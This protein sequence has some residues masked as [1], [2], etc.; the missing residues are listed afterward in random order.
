[1]LELPFVI[2]YCS[3]PRPVVQGDNA[4]LSEPEWDAP[5]PHAQAALSTWEH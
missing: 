2:T 1:M 4:W 3:W 5:Y